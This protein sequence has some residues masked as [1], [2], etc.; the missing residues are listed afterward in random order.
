MVTRSAMPLF[1]LVYSQVVTRAN[2]MPDLFCSWRM[3]K[4]SAEGYEIDLRR[5][6]QLSRSRRAPQLHA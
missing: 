6:P 2:I 3:R 5:G 4:A 1:V